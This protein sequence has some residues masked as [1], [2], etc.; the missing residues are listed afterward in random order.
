MPVF[1]EYGFRL[2][3]L[4]FRRRLAENFVGDGDGLGL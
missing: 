3:E 1:S 4:F 2:A